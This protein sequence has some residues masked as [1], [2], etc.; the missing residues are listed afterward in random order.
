[1]ETTG[2]R[3]IPRSGPHFGSRYPEVCGEA[4]VYD[5]LPNKLL[6]RVANPYDFI[7][8]LVLDVWAANRDPRQAIFLDRRIGTSPVGAVGSVPVR[9]YVAH[10]ID[11]GHWFGG[12]AWDFAASVRGAF[13]VDCSVY[14]NFDGPD[15][16]NPWVQAVS[17]IPAQSV[18][19]AAATAPAE[20]V[21]ED[22]QAL[23]KLL[24][25][26]LQRRERLPQL[27]QAMISW[28]A[29]SWLKDRTPAGPL[30]LPANSFTTLRSS[31]P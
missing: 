19:A 11:N 16:W 30:E 25:E 26:F 3:D 13:Y 5:F 23:A 24:A 9:G 1:M 18:W 27:M 10:M 31:F 4:G 6:A 7:G 20:W 22:S 12:P 8:A 2:G 15:A 14:G 29:S 17:E 21:A 28:G